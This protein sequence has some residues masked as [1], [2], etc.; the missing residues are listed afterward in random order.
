MKRGLILIFMLA[1]MG[2]DPIVEMVTG[3]RLSGDC[4]YIAAYTAAYAIDNN[5]P[6]EI[7][8]GF[9]E[10]DGVE[11]GHVHTRVFLDGDG[12][13]AVIDHDGGVYYTRSLW[14]AFRELRS[15]DVQKL[16]EN[17]ETAWRR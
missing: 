2:C 1:I 9:I 10:V 15:Y 16:F 4:K 8:Y 17:M 6:Y 5:L 7:V 13:W 14:G 11:V 3:E 12:V